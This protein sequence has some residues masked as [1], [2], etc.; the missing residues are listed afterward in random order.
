[1]ASSTLCVACAQL[2]QKDAGLAVSKQQ[3]LA[4]KTTFGLTSY[5]APFR[6]KPTKRSLVMSPMVLTGVTIGCGFF[7]FVMFLVGLGFWTKDQV[8]PKANRPADPPAPNELARIREVAV[9]ERFPSNIAPPTAKK[10]IRDLIA[11]I[12]GENDVK[13]DNFLVMHMERRSELRGM[14]FVMGDACRMDG[15]RARSFQTSVEAVRNGFDRDSGQKR[16]A[17]AKDDGQHSGFWNAYMSQ[18][19]AQGGMESDAGIAA[20]TQ[21]IGPE[22]KSMR[23]GLVRQLASAKRAEATRALARAAVFDVD[24][25]VREAAIKALKED[26]RGKDV[27]GEVFVRAIR[28]PM[29]S[30][31]KQAAH[32]ML[33]LERTDLLPELAAFL[34]EKAPGDPEDKV[35]DGKFAC[36]VREVVKINHHRNC[37]LCHPPAQTGQTHEVPGVMPIPG[38]PFPSSPSEAYGNAQSSNDPMVRAD[39]TYLRQDFSV[40][41]PVENAAPWPEMQR[42][43][44][45][46]RSRVVEGQELATLQNLVASRPA[47]FQSENHKAALLVLRRLS[48]Q[49]ADPN[50]AA[51]QRVLDNRVE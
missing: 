1:M 4:C 21:M 42:F 10:R 22:R 12:K 46:V 37:L 36:V 33:A 26:G 3:C 50:Q 18:A 20:L 8:R 14:P 23:A 15:K 2:P 41:M 5:G 17:P 45:L 6:I 32:A 11:M 51:W 9:D 39:T 16:G 28:Y 35:V 30:V 29:A 34:D 40:M 24:L 7:M 44:F 38:A 13:Q 25:D 31:A 27:S 19:G 49:D 43:D 47:T 48:G